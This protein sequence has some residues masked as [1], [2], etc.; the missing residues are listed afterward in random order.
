MSGKPI[1]FGT[2]GWRGVISD[3]FTET[4]VSRV[5]TGFGR[6][7]LERSGGVAP[8]V[9]IGYDLRFGSERFARLA[10]RTLRGL[11]ITTLI[12]DQ[13]CPTPVISYA[14]Q[15]RNL[16][17]GL[18]IT[19]SHNPYYFNGIK[20]RIDRGVSPPD[21][22]LEDIRKQ[23]NDAPVVHG[24]PDFQ[25]VVMDESLV[26]EYREGLKKSVDK[27][28]FSGLDRVIVVDYLNGVLQGWV[29][30]LFDERPIQVH[31]LNGWWDPT[32]GG[33]AAEPIPEELEELRG[34]VAREKALIGV[35]FD[36]D[37][38]RLA[39][40]DDTCRI[41]TA[42]ELFPLLLS[43][44]YSTGRKGGVARTYPTTDWV[45]RVA[46][47]ANEPTQ[48]VP[49]GFKNLSPYLVRREAIMAGEESGGIAFAHH[50]PERDALF[51]FL[52]VLEM[53]YETRAPLSALVSRF[54][55]RYGELH[56]RRMDFMLERGGWLNEMKSRLKETV[57]N[58][59][60]A[61]VE[62]ESDGIKFRITDGEWVMIRESGTEPV[63]RIY[64]ESESEENLVSRLKKIKSLVQEAGLPI[65]PEDLPK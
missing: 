16:D 38:D 48:D 47:E 17:G 12:S 41:L 40:V 58:E 30:K 3:D 26:D 15:T 59:L 33:G 2:D 14:I 43:Y 18:I 60:N 52:F 32:F 1:R 10:G 11:D 50:I 45:K 21:E 42:Q 55:K 29:E 23:L 57:C 22:V 13:P 19:A 20:L 54:V 37:G 63:L 46:D 7:L 62:Q 28:L 61:T 31:A 25:G 6:W 24:S 34:V 9:A 56:Y 64:A 44:L 8:S 36:G 39:V 5:V 51:V 53:L 27:A 4:N 49:V 35:A 65:S